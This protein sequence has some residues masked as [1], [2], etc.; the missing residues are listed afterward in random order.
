[1]TWR[2]GGNIY[3]DGRLERGILH[4]EDGRIAK[5]TKSGAVDQDFGDRAILPGA[6]DVHVHFRDPGMTH[7]EDWTTGSTSAAFGGVTSVV[8]MPNTAPPTS[9]LKAVRD[10]LRIAGSKSVVDFAVWS[11]VTW[12]LDDLPQMLNWTPGI[13]IYLGATTGDLLLDDNDRVRRA[14]DIAGAAGKQVVLH[15]E[16]QRVLQELRRTEERL[17]DH[18]STRPPL[19]E[20]EAIYDVL[21]ALPTLD[22]P[23]AIHVAHIASIDAVQAAEAAKFSRGV[24]PH[25]LLL[26]VVGC[27]DAHPTRGKMN[28]PLRTPESRAGLW[29]AF[30]AGRIPVLESDHA[31]HTVAEKNDSFHAAPAGVPGV[32]TLLPVML[33]KVAAGDV[34]LHIVVDAATRGPAALI[35]ATDRGALE[36]GMKADFAVYDLDSPAPVDQKSLHSKCGWSPF[37]GMAAV[38]PSHVAL[39]GQWIV[40]DGE[41]VGRAGGGQSIFTLPEDP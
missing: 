16:A 20:V 37:D 39:A 18:D 33:G 3:R 10:K 23:P 29:D 34:P 25:H 30:A 13:K 1:M 5:I 24:C 40:D 32:E 35:G 36:P 22:K 41:L 21:K 4:I 7:K 27:C 6:I 17:E 38:F 19:A 14:L 31:P 2:V 11:G 12:Y 28:P 26:D 9:T 8:D 15:C